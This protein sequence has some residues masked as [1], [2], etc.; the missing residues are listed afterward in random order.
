MTNKIN[1]AIIIAGGSG[2][3]LMP[4]TKNKPK[5]LLEIN[6]VPILLR[7]INWLKRN[8]IEH[9]VIGVAHKKEKIIKYI[10]DNDNFNLNIDISVHT[11]KGDTGEAFRL[12]IS[13]YSKEE[14]FL[15]M[16][17]DEL[18]NINLKGISDMHFKYK[19]IVTMALAPFNCKFSVVNLKNKYVD[20]FEYG[21][22]IPYLLVS[23]GIYIFNKEILQYI[24]KTGTIEENTFVK[25]YKM[26]KIVGY[27]F[28]KQE[29]W[30]SVNTFKDIKDAEKIV[31]KWK[32]L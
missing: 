26:K 31:D 4:L 8:E 19:P 9:L 2:S 3:R 27:K 17:S 16:N 18:T 11:L 22:K 7:I 21:K 24:P 12:A 14:N 15:A 32:F 5:T 28:N 20:N 30:I 1:E 10:K 23:T 29:D 13:R 6:N 25:L